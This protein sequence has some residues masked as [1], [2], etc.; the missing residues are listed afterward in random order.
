MEFSDIFWSE[1]LGGSYVD[2]S[3]EQGEAGPKAHEDQGKGDEELF[4][5]ILTVVGTSSTKN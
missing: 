4:A 5:D 2:D 1:P 3:P